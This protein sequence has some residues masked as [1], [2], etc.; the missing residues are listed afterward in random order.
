MTTILRL[1]AVEQRVGLKRSAIYK[2]IKE[3]TFPAPAAQLGPR[4][5]GWEETEIEQWIQEKI[6]QRKAG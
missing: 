1:H 5:V 6:Q 2:R 3:G 4:T